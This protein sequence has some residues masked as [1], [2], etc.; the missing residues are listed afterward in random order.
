MKTFIIAEAGVNHNGSLDM[1]IQLIDAAASAGADAVKFQTFRAAQLASKVAPKAHYQTRTTSSAESQFDMLKK[2]ELDEAAHLKLIAH[3]KTRGIEFLST[4]FDSTTLDLLTGRLGLTTIKVSSGDIT[5]APFLLEIARASQRV[6]LSTGMCALSEVEAALGV[7][8]FGFVAAADA[9]PGPAA[10]DAAYASDAG[11]AAL[12]ARVAVLHCTTE[13]PAPIAEV[14][15][16]AVETLTA[17]FGLETGYSDHTVGIHIPIAAVARGSTI[18]EKHF[19]LNRELPGPDHKASLE[20]TE[21]TAMVSAIRDIEVCLG[22]GIKR[23]TASE[24]RNKIVARKSLVLARD[25]AVGEP[26]ALACKRPGN[27]V[28]P[29]LYWQLSGTPANRQYAADEI[30]DA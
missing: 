24:S 26:L 25:V 13:Y 5:N 9:P 19:T 6:I 14:N 23:P 2:L 29:Y 15:L 1:A 4:P 10:F 12:K 8:A 27:G 30:L 3:A 20:P 16:R 18:I 11:Q 22:D 28:S 17:A 7:L 21:L